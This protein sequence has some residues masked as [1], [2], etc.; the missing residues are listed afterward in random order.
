MGVH[1]IQAG[2]P[3]C[4][5]TSEQVWENLRERFLDATGQGG[6]LRIFADA[7]HFRVSCLL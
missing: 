7:H 3:T 5:V 6:P 2:S 4:L 1:L